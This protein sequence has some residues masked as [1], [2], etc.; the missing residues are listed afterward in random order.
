MKMGTWRV[1]GLLAGL[2][3]GWGSIL[4]LPAQEGDA[5]AKIAKVECKK[6]K[7]PRYG[8][9]TDPRANGKAQED[10]WRM[11]AEYSTSGGRGVGYDGR[12]TFHDEV[13]F[14]WNVLIPRRNGKSILMKRT[15][16]YMDVQDRSPDHYADLYLRPGFISR[17][18]GSG[19]RPADLLFYIQ[20][21]INGKTVYKYR[22]DREPNRWWE[23]EPPRVLVKDELMTRGE[24][25]FA[26]LDYDFYEQMK[27][28]A[29]AAR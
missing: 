23:S 2:L 20:V 27:P 21:K 24:T 1:V 15:V 14:E 19:V 28:A 18:L 22:N 9:S 3:A 13:T 7:T 11:T 6:V 5:G 16:S 26:S 29:A 12:T 25:P 10:W 8:E 17:N 4:S